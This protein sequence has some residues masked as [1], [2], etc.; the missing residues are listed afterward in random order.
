MLFPNLYYS[1]WL[2]E[3]TNH[4]KGAKGAEGRFGD[5]SW[6]ISCIGKGPSKETIRRFRKW[7]EL[8]RAKV[9]SIFR[10]PL[11]FVKVSTH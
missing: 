2:L 3:P 8:E 9:Y 7:K 11:T 6:S 10:S 1:V 5:T 4:C